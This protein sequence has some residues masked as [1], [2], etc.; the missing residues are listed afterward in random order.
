[1]FDAIIEGWQREQASRYLRE[2]TI[3]ARV[4]VVRRLAQFSGQYPWQWTAEEMEAFCTQTRSG[5]GRLAF[6]T[7]R[8]Y[9]NTIRLFCEY[10][11]DDRYGWVTEC[12]ERFG[13]APAQ[14]CHEW[15]TV[16]HIDEYEGDPRRRALTYDEVQA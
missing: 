13:R 7:L 6:S 9:Q 12:L 8:G 3:A 14:I 5:H 16:A 1:M 4:G 2:A 11:T 10:V 15:N